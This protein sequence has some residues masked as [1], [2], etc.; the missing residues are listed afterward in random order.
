M[1]NVYGYIR[2]STKGQ[3]EERQLAG[4]KYAIELML[5][6]DN[7]HLFSFF[8]EHDMICDLDNYK[9]IAHYGE[10]INS[11]IL[12]WMKAGE[13]ELTEENYEAYCEEMK[14]FYMNY[15]YDRLF[16]SCG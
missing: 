16:E 11:R 12:R 8:T 3:K 5:P 14:D 6:Y 7:I 10:N 1:G 13:H 15:D 9:D 4:E 2:V